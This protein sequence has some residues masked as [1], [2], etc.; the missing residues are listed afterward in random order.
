[1]KQ[2]ALLALVAALVAGCGGSS[3]LS[4]AQYEQRLRT[5]GKAVQATITA[6]TSSAS[7]GS[8]AT[9]VRRVDAASAAVKSA[10]DDLHS[11]KP[12]A[13]A[14]ADNAAIVTALQTIESGLVRLK[15]AASKGDFVEAQ[16]VATAIESSP[17]LKAAQKATDDLKA[18]GYKVGIIGS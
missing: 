11:I 8:L 12:P 5:D 6:L 10:A 7:S 3:R 1:M 4:K 17:Q 15:K 2:L 18:K 14:A 9:V 16:K 13:D